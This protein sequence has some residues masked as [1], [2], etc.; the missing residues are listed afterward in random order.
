MHVDVSS[1]I[2][3]HDGI[4]IFFRNASHQVVLSV[5]QFEGAIEPLAFIAIVEADANDRR[6]VIANDIGNLERSPAKLR[7]GAASAAV[8][9]F[10]SQPIDL[11]SFEESG[12]YVWMGS[13]IAPVVDDR[14]LVENCS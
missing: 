14:L 2:Q 11:P 9:V 6:I 13:M 7:D 4:G 10:D 5:R 12:G 1:R 3:N 8:L